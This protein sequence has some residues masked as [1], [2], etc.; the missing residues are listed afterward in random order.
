MLHKLFLHIKKCFNRV[1]LIATKMCNRK[2][3]M[4]TEIGCEIVCVQ[5]QGGNLGSSLINVIKIFTQHVYELNDEVTQGEILQAI[6]QGQLSHIDENKQIA[7]MNRFR[8]AIATGI[9]HKNLRL[10][11]KM[12]KGL[13]T[14]GQVEEYIQTNKFNK[15]MA[16][17]EQ[18]SYQEILILATL[19][20]FKI[21]YK[22]QEQLKETKVDKEV[23]QQAQETD[24]KVKQRER[25]QE[26]SIESRTVELTKKYLTGQDI[27]QE[28]PQH[29]IA[30]Y[31][32]KTMDEDEFEGYYSSLYRTGLLMLNTGMYD[33]TDTRSLTPMFDEL[34]TLIDFQDVLDKD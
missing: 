10:M 2:N 30:P 6:T 13:I 19:Y 7:L 8:I 4:L 17:L 29:E 26:A 25:E 20:R 18:L 14:N 31:L 27:S 32:E 28:D 5:L 33:T 9:A 16:I 3:V 1:K 24:E 22:A 15:Y 21:F 23:G 11:A 12:V 34:M